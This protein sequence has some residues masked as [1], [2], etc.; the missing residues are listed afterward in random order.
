MSAHKSR[1]SCGDRKV[2]ALGI[3]AV[4]EAVGREFRRWTA[5]FIARRLKS[6]PQ[7][8]IEG[9][10]QARSAPHARHLPAI[11]SDDLLGPAFLRA[12]GQAEIAD[13]VVARKHLHAAKAALDEIAR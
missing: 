13:I 9:W 11:L 7:R 8:T 3:E 1:H 12:L 5:A 4:N 6:V 10:Q 2:N